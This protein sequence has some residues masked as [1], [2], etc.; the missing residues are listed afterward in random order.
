MAARRPDP[1]M[2]PNRTPEG[3]S[4]YVWQW[5]TSEA[6]K[7]TN[8]RAVLALKATSVPRHRLNSRLWLCELAVS[9]RGGVAVP[10]DGRRRVAQGFEP[11]DVMAAVG[12]ALADA[13]LG[14][15]A[16]DL[17]PAPTSAANRPTKMAP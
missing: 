1:F 3:I 12:Q 14:E 8:Y 5:L 9:A 6:P 4:P 2:E 11:A 7:C 15:G 10:G 16:R 13:E 17:G